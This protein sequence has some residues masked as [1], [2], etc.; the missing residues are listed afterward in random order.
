MS[1]FRSYFSKNNTLIEDNRTN[2]SQNPVCEVSYGTINTLV[3]R[4]IFDLDLTDLQAK[5]DA[6][7]Y[8]QSNITSHTL[9][10]TN[11]IRYIPELVGGR[12]VDTETDRAASFSLE[13]FNV[14]EDWDE[15]NGYD[16][17][18][19]DEEFPL[20]PWQASN[21]F[22]R[23]TGVAWTDEGAFTTG[24][25]GASGITGNT[26]VL[27]TQ[28]FEDGSENISIDISDYVN[29]QLFTGTTGFTATTFGLGLKFT[30][31]LEVLETEDRKAVAFHVKDTHTFYEPYVETLIDDS[32]SD[33]RNYFYMDKDNELFLYAKAGNSATNVTVSA[34]TIIDYTGAVVSVATGS[35]ISEVRDGV[36]KIS[37][38]IDPDT[39]P[40]AVI[41]TDRWRVTQ[42]SRVKNIDQKFYLIN[43][44]NYY[45]FDLSS[46][47]NFDN[48]RI[49]IGGIKEI[50]KIRR[51]DSRIIEVDIKELYPNQNT[52]LP[53]DLEYRIFVTQDENHQ[54]DV[55]PFTALDR[56]LVGYEFTLDTSWLIPQDYYLEVK[57]S[58]GGVFIVRKPI[59]FTIVSDGVI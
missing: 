41:F 23:K 27:A 13:L 3:S 51:G 8:T 45:N 9:N 53:L 22:D 25:T 46:R 54:I 49:N 7:T 39:Y 37:A 40:D 30:D 48:Y 11:T 28:A 29:A 35:S 10:L 52:N 58:N 20:I 15:G 1:R 33:D 16:F 34:V 2:N 18:Y 4:F 5:V 24:A 19:S 21:W 42:N 38:N 57:I 50:E 32:I 36:Y 26:L 6:G 31:N 59:R 17:V 56:T 55:I 43:E 14:V 47:I 44:D 12:Y